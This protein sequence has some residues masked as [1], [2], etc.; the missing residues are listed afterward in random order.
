METKVQEDD[1]SKGANSLE[2]GQDYEEESNKRVSHAESA[3]HM[4]G[5]TMQ[6]LANLL[7]ERMKKKDKNASSTSYTMHGVKVHLLESF[8]LAPLPI[9]SGCS[10]AYV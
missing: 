9:I 5:H 2:V 1:K 8:K 6:T 7:V 4:I 10:V 3:L